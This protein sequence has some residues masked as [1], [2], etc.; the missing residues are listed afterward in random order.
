MANVIGDPKLKFYPKSHVYKYGKT[1]LESVTSWVGSFN[2]PFK[3]FDPSVAKHSAKKHTRETGEKI[4]ARGIKA[5][6]KAITDEGTAVHAEI[7]EYIKGDNGPLNLF[8][9]KNPRAKLGVA[10]YNK[11]KGR[12]EPT[13]VHAEAR[14]FSLELGL[15]GTIDLLLETED[16]V[17]LVDWKTNRKMSGVVPSEDGKR[18]Q[19]VFTLPDTKMAKYTM[20]LNTYA[21]IL[22]KYY[23][24][25]IK[26]LKLV[27]LEDTEARVMDLPYI[28]RLVEELIQND[29]N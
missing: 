9:P 2:P 11:F 22:E 4:G 27:H 23:G 6:W 28:P 18:E 17:V 5:Q 26:A 8:Q 25:K 24:F 3:P 1:K 19:S 16:G 21:Y 12:F 20:Q 15:A 7:E 10:E 13:K 14:V 29:I